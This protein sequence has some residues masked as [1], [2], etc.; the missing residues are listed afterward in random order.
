IDNLLENALRYTTAPGRVVLGAHSGAELAITL[1][2]TAPGVADAALARLGER[3][4]RV[5][6]SRSRAHGGSG[7]G[8]ALCRRIVQAHRGRLAF[9]HSPL[10]GLRVTLT[11]PR[12]PA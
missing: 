3:F 8:L 11:L 7:L 5:E 1:D 6:A 9:G 12:Q 10:G 2:D 4:Y